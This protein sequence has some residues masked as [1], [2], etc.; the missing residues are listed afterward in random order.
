MMQTSWQTGATRQQVWNVLS[1]GWLYASWVVG[2]SRIRKVDPQWPAV[3]ARLHHSVGS[4]PLLLNDE[5]RVL[6]SRPARLLRLLAS[7][8]PVGEALVEIELTDRTDAPGSTIE[9]REELVSGPARL[10]AAPLLKAA[11]VP[12]NRESLRRLSFMAEGRAASGA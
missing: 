9:L 3:G 4:W 5:T 1:E 12:R 10:I 8:R 7:T 6:T 2:A 11:L